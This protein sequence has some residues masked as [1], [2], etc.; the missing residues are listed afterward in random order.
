MLNH[1]TDG[2]NDPDDVPQMHSNTLSHH[3]G[4]YCKY[5]YNYYNNYSMMGQAGSCMT[6]TFKS[7][8]KKIQ[9][10]SAETTCGCCYFWYY[11]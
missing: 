9:M 10:F 6:Q 5:Y 7:S 2:L 3:R 8:V 1:Q 11:I 4:H